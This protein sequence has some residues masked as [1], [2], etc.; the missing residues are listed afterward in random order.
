MNIIGHIS[1]MLLFLLQCASGAALAGTP[2]P[3]ELPGGSIIPVEEAR[4]VHDSKGALFLDV[5]NPINYGRGHLPAAMSLPYD[6]NNS[7]RYG[8]EALLRG[9]PQDKG[10]AIIIY[11][12]GSTG[13]K[14]YEASK[15]AIAAGYTGI[16]W[17]REGY[18]AWEQAGYPVRRGPGRD[19]SR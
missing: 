5:R 4:A 17:M 15:A 1:I 9:L 8:K 14:S 11:S 12:H 19:G 18:S 13:W 2:A 3:R 10:A 6:S 16:R 7:G